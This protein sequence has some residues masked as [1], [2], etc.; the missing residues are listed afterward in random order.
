MSSEVPLSESGSVA[1]ASRPACASQSRNR[2]M[3]TYQ[4][5]RREEARAAVVHYDLV[6]LLNTHTSFNQLLN[7]QLVCCHRCIGLIN[8]PSACPATRILPSGR[9]L[10]SRWQQSFRSPVRTSRS[11]RNAK[12]VYLL[13][14]LSAAG[15]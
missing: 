3:T 6:D 10:D 12:N 9:Q 4:L 14:S 13:S 15:C 11:Y 7:C 5:A 2:P 1:S 8:T